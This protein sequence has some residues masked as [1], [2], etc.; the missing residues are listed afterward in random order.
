MLPN[1]LNIAGIKQGL[2]LNI[3]GCILSKINNKQKK[4]N[5]PQYE[6][7]PGVTMICFHLVFE[8]LI[9]LACLNQFIIRSVVLPLA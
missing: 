6:R 5:S 9:A 4:R 7:L 8:K 2:N 3:H 1:W